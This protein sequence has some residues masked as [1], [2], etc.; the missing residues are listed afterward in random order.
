[1][2]KNLQMRIKCKNQALPPLHL[3]QMKG[4][5][6][7]CLKRNSRRA[8]RTKVSPAA[9][10]AEGWNTHNSQAALI[11]YTKRASKYTYAQTENRLFGET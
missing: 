4:E 5:G 7:R 1:M 6:A 3:Q 8:Q 11:L 2:E 9:P 10:A